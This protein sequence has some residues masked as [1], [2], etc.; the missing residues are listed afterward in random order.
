V[1]G[2]TSPALKPSPRA[3]T[4]PGWSVMTRSMP[5]FSRTWRIWPRVK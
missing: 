4:M 2:E 5:A 3:S 1:R